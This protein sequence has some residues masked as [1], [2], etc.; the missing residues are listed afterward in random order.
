MASCTYSCPAMMHARL[1][2]R[3]CL[4]SMR[5]SEK[6]LLC[7]DT[8]SSHDHILHICSLY[9]W[10]L[11]VGIPR[12]A[13]QGTNSRSQITIPSAAVLDPTDSEL[14]PGPV[15]S[16]GN[17]QDGKKDVGCPGASSRSTPQ[18]INSIGVMHQVLPWTGSG[19]ST[20]WLG[21]SASQG[22]C[23]RVNPRAL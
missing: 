17:Q 2:P 6:A 13:G 4:V 8:S 15:R 23:T 12:L 5:P 10:R 18:E 9:L 21:S 16:G 22:A 1:N 7:L 3:L 14:L 20:S 11:L 19:I